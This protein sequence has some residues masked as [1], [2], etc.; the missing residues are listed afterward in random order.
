[1]DSFALAKSPLNFGAGP[2]DILDAL[3]QP[4]T[5]QAALGAYDTVTEE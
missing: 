3:D 4:I 1:L 2:F 5:I